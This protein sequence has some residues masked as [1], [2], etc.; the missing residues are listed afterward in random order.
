MRHKVGET[1]TPHL[2][3]ARGNGQNRCF[4]WRW[5]SKAFNPKRH[6]RVFNS[7][8]LSHRLKSR[9]RNP[10]VKCTKIARISRD[11]LATDP[12]RTT[13]GQQWISLF[14]GG[15][16]PEASLTMGGALAQHEEVGLQ[17]QM[18]FF[19]GRVVGRNRELYKASA[20]GAFSF[21]Q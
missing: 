9:P 17:W 4:F 7:E 8:V 3:S 19:V 18:S 10:E 1:P 21:F 2:G 5:R 13:R 6:P 20:L 16:T 11:S 15:Q 14:S 12:R